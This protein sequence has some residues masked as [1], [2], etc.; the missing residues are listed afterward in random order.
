[1]EKMLALMVMVVMVVVWPHVVVTDSNLWVG[2]EEPS[3]FDSSQGTVK[4]IPNIRSQAQCAM[5]ASMTPSSYMFQYNGGDCVLYDKK[6]D[7]QGQYKLPDNTNTASMLYTRLHN[8][9]IDGNNVYEEGDEM[10]DVDCRQRRC[11]NRTLEPI[12]FAPGLPCRSPFVE[13]DDGCFYLHQTEMTWCDA[14]K[15]CVGLGGDLAYGPTFESLHQ[16][17]VANANES[18]WIQIS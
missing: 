15:Y 13:Y 7:S 16:F 17:L 4:N 12:I 18:G 1:M 8:V 9:C 14:R 5:R 2:I 10:T 6:E 11:T 3:G